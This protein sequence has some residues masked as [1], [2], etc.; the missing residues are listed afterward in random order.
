MLD[1][2][3][4]IIKDA[5]DDFYSNPKV[6]IKNFGNADTTIEDGG[7]YISRL[8]AVK[9]QINEGSTY[10]ISFGYSKMKAYVNEVIIE[11]K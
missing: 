9:S 11:K 1:V 2:L 3:D 4:T 8:V 10:N 6:T 7:E 5:Q